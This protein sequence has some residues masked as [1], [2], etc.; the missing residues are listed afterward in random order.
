MDKRIY[1]LIMALWTALSAVPVFAEPANDTATSS[2]CHLS[3][4]ANL[5]RWTTFTPDLGLE[6]HI[7]PSLSIVVNSTWTSWQW[8]GGN[9]RYALLEAAPE[10]RW[11]PGEKKGWYIGAMFKAGR[12]NYMLSDKGIQGDLMGGGISGGY[13]LQLNKALD[14]DFSLGLG[15]INAGCEKYEI[16]DDVRVRCG[17]EMKNWWG[18]INAGVTLSWKLF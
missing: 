13:Q 5:L 7:N 10:V 16:I 2:G 14:I 11:Y 4:R 1:C 12:F 9:R 18:P 8:N 6:W 3:L 17:N 15:Y